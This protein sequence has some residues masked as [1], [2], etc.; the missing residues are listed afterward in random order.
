MTATARAHRHMDQ[1]L[2]DG[3]DDDSQQER[4]LLVN[5][6]ETRRAELKS[7]DRFRVGGHSFQFLVEE[8]R[9]LPPLR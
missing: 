6:G 5:G 3:Q 9:H 8:R 1:P 4:A 2:V 7:E